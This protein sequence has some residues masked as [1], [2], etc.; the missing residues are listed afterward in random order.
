MADELTCSSWGG[1]TAGMV[2]LESIRPID[3][4]CVELRGFE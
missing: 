3:W 2:G 1:N 4:Q